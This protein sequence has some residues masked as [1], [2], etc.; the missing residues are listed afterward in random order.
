MS[1]EFLLFR[2]LLQRCNFRNKLTIK[3]MVCE[4]ARNENI[5][6]L[7]V[8]EHVRSESKVKPMVAGYAQ[9]ES[10]IKTNGF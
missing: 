9:S 4:H 1:L 2:V 7:M 8:F 10:T 3:P 5:I 6:T